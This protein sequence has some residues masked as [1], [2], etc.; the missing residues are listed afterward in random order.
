MFCGLFFRKIC[1][2]KNSRG[3]FS[4]KKAAN[5]FLGRPSEDRTEAGAAGQPSNGLWSK[6]TLFNSFI[7]WL[8]KEC[9]VVVGAIKEMNSIAE[10]WNHFI[11]ELKSF[12]LATTSPIQS[13]W[14]RAKLI[15]RQNLCE[16]ARPIAL[17]ANF[18]FTYPPRQQKMHL[19]CRD[20]FKKY[21]GALFSGL[22]IIWW[23]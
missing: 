13:R 6:L 16:S 15:R 10:N 19:F 7:F 2:R 11:W 1:V 3:F 23:I 22:E 17:L 21:N 12:H 20:F 18:C 4:P 14:S 5:S 9:R 8:S